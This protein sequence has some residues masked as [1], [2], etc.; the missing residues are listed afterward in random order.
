MSESKNEIIY[1]GD[2]NLVLPEAA[3]ITSTITVSNGEV[4]TNLTIGSGTELIISSGG[5]SV[6]VILHGGIQYISSGGG[7]SNTSIGGDIQNEWLADGI[8]YVASGGSAFNTFINARGAQIVQGGIVSGAVLSG[9]LGDNNWQNNRAQ[10][11]VFSGAFVNDVQGEGQYV[12]QY[13]Y[14]GTVNNTQFKPVLDHENYGAPGIMFGPTYN[15]STSI[16][17]GADEAVT[18][19]VA[20]MSQVISGGGIANN[21]T[22]YGDNLGYFFYPSPGEDSSYISI[23]AMA[24][25]YVLDGGTA[26]RTDISGGG[27]SLALVVWQVIQIFMTE[28]SKYILVAV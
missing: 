2:S 8:Q 23:V 28:V 19:Y 12:E 1:G 24:A 13:I 6:D 5:N 10:Q 11:Y 16:S 14:G 21:T 4:F 7:A 20:T 25:Q 22:L 17:S 15:F 3:E 27:Y 26:N 9:A 18:N